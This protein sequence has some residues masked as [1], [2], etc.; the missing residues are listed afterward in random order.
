MA[1]GRVRVAAV[2]DYELIVAGVARLLSQFPQQLDVCDRIVIGDPIDTPI[3]VALFDTYGRV[4]IAAPALR[5]FV[6]Q[7]RDAALRIICSGAG[8]VQPEIVRRI[9]ALIDAEVEVGSYD[10][11]LDT[12]TLAYAIVK[13]A[14]AFLFNDAVA[15]I[16]GDVDRLREIEAALLG[17]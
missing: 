2:N 13:L 11:P 16:R 1:G 4:G 15:G 10:P 9:A 3:D 17:V 14:E 8:R 6:E 7:E 12:S 5:H